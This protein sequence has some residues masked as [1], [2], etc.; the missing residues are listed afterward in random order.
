MSVHSTESLAAATSASSATLRTRAAC[1]APPLYP[2][3]PRA[4]KPPP[5]I[6]ETSSM[7]AFRSVASHSAY[8]AHNCVM[9]SGL[10]ARH[11]SG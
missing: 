9:L 6:R 1:Q 3:T 2:C 11:G 5:R 4:R 7:S 8:P 10:E